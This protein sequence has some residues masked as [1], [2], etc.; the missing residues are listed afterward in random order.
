MSNTAMAIAVCPS[1]RCGRCWLSVGR[2]LGS[3]VSPAATLRGRY[4]S[5]VARGGLGLRVETQRRL[6]A[7]VAQ[8]PM[9]LAQQVRDPLGH[10]FG[11]LGS[12]DQFAGDSLLGFL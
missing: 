5:F 4:A 11:N 6:I 3:T 1:R 10:G 12:C 2:V 7:W 8:A 9:Q